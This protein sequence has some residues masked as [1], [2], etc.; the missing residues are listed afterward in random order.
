ML[1]ILFVD[2]V[3]TQITNSFCEGDGFTFQDS[4]YTTGGVYFYPYLTQNGCDSII[5]L[6]LYMAPDTDT[7]IYYETCYASPY[8]IAGETFDQAGSYTIDLLNENN[9]DSTIYL[10]LVFRDSSFSNTVHEMCEG[11]T[12]NFDG[13]WERAHIVINQGS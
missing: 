3:Y 1:D 6:S 2:T 13:V 8:T 11:D 9:C 12:I 5:V 10:N 7:T 4:L